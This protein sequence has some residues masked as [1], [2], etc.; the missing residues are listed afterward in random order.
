MSISNLIESSFAAWSLYT[1]PSDLKPLTPDSTWILGKWG[2]FEPNEKLTAS[3][4]KKDIDSR[5]ALLVLAF[6]KYCENTT[7]LNKHF[8]IPEF[9]FRCKAG[10]YPL[11]EIKEEDELFGQCTLQ[12]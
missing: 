11:V 7:A 8:V 4:I 1:G 2:N 12:F 6:T 10:P 9:F 5:I 3:S